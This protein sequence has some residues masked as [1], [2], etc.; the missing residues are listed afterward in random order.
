MD[1]PDSSLIVATLPIRWSGYRREFDA[2]RT[3]NVE[4][5]SGADTELRLG[6]D[7]G[8]SGC[9]YRVARSGR[10]SLRSLVLDAECL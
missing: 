6:V 8:D 2:L 1:E 5:S 7:C 4:H 9:R 10:G 3:V